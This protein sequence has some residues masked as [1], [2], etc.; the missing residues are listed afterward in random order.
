MTLALS[1]L[2]MFKII[3]ILLFSLPLVL[4]AYQ[5]GYAE[6]FVPSEGE[7][8]LLELINEARKDPLAMAESLGMARETVLHDLPQL[9]DVLTGGLPP[10]QFDEKLY[11]AAFGHTEEMIANIYYSHTSLDGRTYAERIRERGYLPAGCGESLGMVAF[12]NLMGP[13]E[14]AGIIFKSI[15]LAE[16]DPQTTEG[17]NILNPEMTEAGIVLGSGQFTRGGSTLNAYVAT[18]DFAKPVADTKAVER[19]L[20]GMLNAARNDPGLALLNAGIDPAGAAEAYGDLGWAL[21]EPLPPLAWNETL[22]GTATAHCRDMRDQFYFDTVSLDGLTPFDRVESTGYDPAYV[23]ES[24]GMISAAADVG[25]GDSAFEVARR[26]YEEM[27]KAD[28][29]PQSDVERNIF[30]PFVTEV[31]IGVE[32][33]FR[34][35]GDEQSISYVVVADFAEPRGQRCF[36]VGTVYEDRNHNGLIDD[37]EGIP[38]LKITVKPGYSAI[39]EIVAERSDPMGHYQINLSNIPTGLI[40][41]YVEW[42]GDVLGPFSFV[43]ERA[44]VNVLKNIRIEPKSRVDSAGVARVDEKKLDRSMRICY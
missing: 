14:A 5:K 3:K 19:A 26:L 11:E 16:L 41:L 21:T 4:G 32:T 30:S 1:K 38:G 34:V 27:L 36:V 31:G 43:V 18:L 35:P 24:L 9:N 28:V 22:H 42:E 29:D 2:S 10:L 13:A 20:V 8:S 17:R 44:G 23:G 33:A 7:I 39:W 40:E 12:Q 6:K 15:F 25:Q 37:D